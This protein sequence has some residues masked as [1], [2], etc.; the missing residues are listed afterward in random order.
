MIRVPTREPLMHDAGI[1][2]AAETHGLLAHPD[3]L[4]V[5]TACPSGRERG[6]CSDSGQDQA[7]RSHHGEASGDRHSILHSSGS[8]MSVT[9]QP[10]TLSAR[11]ETGTMKK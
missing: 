6:S 2:G 11:S 3:V 8:V 1:V 5:V 4:G 9:V 7:G 10:G